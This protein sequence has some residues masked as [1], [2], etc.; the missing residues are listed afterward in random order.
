MFVE[1]HRHL[2]GSI[3]PET[4]WEIINNSSGF[5]IADSLFDVQQQVRLMR[6]DGDFEYFCTRFDILNKLRW[7]DSALILVANQVCSDIKAEQI[8]HATITVSL[9][10]FAR[11]GKLATA[12]ER[13][14]S[15]FNIA[16][17]EFGVDVNFLLSVSYGW[18]TELQMQAI[19]LVKTL[20]RF[21]AGIDFVGD[22][23]L[24]RWSDYMVPLEPWRKKG[25]TIRAH[26]GE[27]PGTAINISKAIHEMGIN[28]IAH[29]IYAT[30]E[31]QREATRLG[32]VFDMSI[33]SNICTHTI[34]LAKH[35]AKKM[36]AT[37]CKITLGAD[38]PI[39]FNCTIQTE[40]ALA[41]AMGVNRDILHQTAMESRIL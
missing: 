19:G 10:K 16:A 4:I 1:S 36:Q 32:I 30:E 37:G 5:G 15:I 27:R 20:D 24:A 35:P 13:F 26:V 6:D 33:H 41:E 34:A 8:E 3:S 28:R 7:D 17:Q 14:F 18:P 25:K 11:S 29:G 39:Q 9:N 38:D 23:S 31:Q 22:E 12:G 40:Y 2:A 21:M